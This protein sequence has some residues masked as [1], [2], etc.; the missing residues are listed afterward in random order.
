MNK[1]F[2]LGGSILQLDLILEAKKM[3]FYTIVLDMDEN[4]IGASWSDEFLHINIADKETV[5]KKAR[6]YNIDVILTSA[7]EIGNVTACW[8]GERLGLKTNSYQT[9]LNT[10][11]KKRM[12]EILLKIP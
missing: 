6:E 12:K 5:L 7:T 3:F 11:D 8:V 4:C 9:S 1:I 10:T 2:I